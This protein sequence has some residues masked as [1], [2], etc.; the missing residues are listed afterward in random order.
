MISF[1]W[2][3]MMISNFLSDIICLMDVIVN[4]FTGSVETDTQKVILDRKK[5]CMKY[6]KGRFFVDLLSSFPELLFE[7]LVKR[8]KMKNV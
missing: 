1:L 7:D 6:L 8:I 2:I 4:F 5:I 3:L